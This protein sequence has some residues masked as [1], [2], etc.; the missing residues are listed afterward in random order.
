MPEPQRKR[1][2]YYTWAELLQRVF[3]FDVAICDRCQGLGRILAFVVDPRRER[4][5]RV[6]WLRAERAAAR[7]FGSE[8][9]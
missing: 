3:L 2:R 1:P 9:A 8:A 4:T 6:L 5:F 7:A